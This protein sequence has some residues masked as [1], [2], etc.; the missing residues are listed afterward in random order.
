[1][2]PAWAGSWPTKQA[3]FIS[4]RYELLMS[5]GQSV[6]LCGAEVRVHIMEKYV[7]R[8]QLSSAVACV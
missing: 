8:N 5:T 6:F 7:Y 3:R 4:K 2:S 1:M